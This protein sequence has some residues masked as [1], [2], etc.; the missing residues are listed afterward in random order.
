MLDIHQLHC[1]AIFWVAYV[2]PFL[3]KHS[4]SLLKFKLFDISVSNQKWMY[5]KDLFFKIFFMFIYFWEREKERD[6][7]WVGERQRAR[8]TQNPKQAPGSELSAES[9]TWGL[10]SQTRCEIMTWAEVRHLTDWAIQEPHQ[11]LFVCFVW[12]E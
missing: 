9:R 12:N 10:N 2:K 6:R 1:Y 8:E 3:P 5:Y 11:D 4:F 7:A